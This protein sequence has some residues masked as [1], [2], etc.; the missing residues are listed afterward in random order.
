MSY[1]KY[2]QELS[3]TKKNSK[4]RYFSRN[5]EEQI[6]IYY[7]DI[8]FEISVEFSSIDLVIEY[9]NNRCN[10]KDSL[11]IPKHMKEKINIIIMEDLDVRI[12]LKK[13]DFVFIELFNA[14]KNI[15]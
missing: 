13:L 15:S 1:I 11:L 4:I 7:D 8:I 6:M 14:M 9:K 3:Q 5:G 10:Y 2:N 12:K